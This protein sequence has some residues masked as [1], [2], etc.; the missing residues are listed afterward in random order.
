MCDPF[1]GKHPN[2]KEYRP[3]LLIGAYSP[4]LEYVFVNH[5]AYMNRPTLT[6]VFVIESYDVFTID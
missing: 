1:V 3:F 5:R 4:H 2:G 6:L